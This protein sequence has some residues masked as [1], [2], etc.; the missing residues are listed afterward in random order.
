MAAEM[1]DRIRQQTGGRKQLRDALRHL[2]AWSARERRAFRIGDI[3]AIF[4]EA[5]GV[6]TRDILERWMGPLPER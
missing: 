4:K 2:V 3:P 5:T 1:D 6:E